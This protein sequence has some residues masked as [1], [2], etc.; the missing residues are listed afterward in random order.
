MLRRGGNE[1]GA[2]GAGRG[3]GARGS[4]CGRGREPPPVTRRGP[5]CASRPARPPPPPP[6]PPPASS[7]SRASLFAAPASSRLG[8]SRSLAPLRSRRRRRLCGRIPVRQARAAALRLRAALAQL[9]PVLYLER[10]EPSS[11]RP[12]RR[13][14]RAPARPPSLARGSSCPP[15]A[16]RPACA[17]RADSARGGLCGRPGL[18]APARAQSQPTAAPARASDLSRSRSPCRGR[19]T[20]RR[21]LG[22]LDITHMSHLC[23]KLNV[24]PTEFDFLLKPA[25]CICQSVWNQHPVD[26]AIELGAVYNSILSH[27]Y[28][29]HADGH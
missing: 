6:P 20:R 1:G 27:L 5:R 21:E 15:V 13:A 25:S 22:L 28:S 17:P 3:R 11:Q 4:R 2:G 16:A 24:F 29:L 18:T 26:Q 19:Y 23:F 14:P 10:A 8:R 9:T 7:A 12:P